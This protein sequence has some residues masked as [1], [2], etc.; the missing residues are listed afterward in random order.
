L[1][2]EGG[3]GFNGQK[4]G[5]GFLIF[6][7]S[8]FQ[9]SAFMKLAHAMLE[10]FQNNSRRSSFGIPES[11]KIRGGRK[12][13][14]IVMTLNLRVSLDFAGY[15]DSDLDEFAG[16]VVA[17]L[18]GNAS[19]PTPPVV[20]ADLDALVTAFHNAVLAALPGGIQ[21]TAAKNA[22][23]T[24]LLDALRKEASYVQTI[25]NHD[26]DVLLTS[27]FYANSTNRAQS[28]LDAPVISKV[29]NLATTKFLVRLTPVLNAKSYNVQTNT[30]GT[31]TWTDAGI[32][33][34]ARRIVLGS[35]VPGT[36]YS[37]RARAIGGSTGSS[38]WSNPVSLMAT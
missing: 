34:Q 21:L 17:S 1:K 28:P 36:T 19:F 15:S 35:L 37:I 29:D 9:L 27:G 4:S 26:L 30:N 31:G 12:T 10:K 16:N 5:V 24:A 20:L 6:N 7:V 25:T 22:A 18:T 14:C 13:Y 8:G 23:R 11:F 38:E 33:T 32:Y 2:L 3:N